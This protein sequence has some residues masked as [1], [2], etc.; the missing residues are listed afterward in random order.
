MRQFNE[1]TISVGTSICIG[2]IPLVTY[3][4]LLLKLFSWTLF[5]LIKV[6][7]STSTLNSTGA[8]DSTY[9]YYDNIQK[10]KGHGSRSEAT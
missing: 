6:M 4:S 1:R 9:T 8:S 5:S 2:K 10:S 7:H 3:S